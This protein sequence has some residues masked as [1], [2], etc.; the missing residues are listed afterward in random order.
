MSVAA[1]DLASG[2]GEEIVIKKDK[3]EMTEAQLKKMIQVA[4]KRKAAEDRRK[5]FMNLMG[6]DEPP[7]PTK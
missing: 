6:D 1:K 3:N 5:K 7:D 2:T 4:A